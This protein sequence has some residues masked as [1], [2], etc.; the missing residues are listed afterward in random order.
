[1]QE[2]QPG[3][4]LRGKLEAAHSNGQ[5]QPGKGAGGGREAQAVN[6]VGLGLQ[7]A[8][9][10]RDGVKRVESIGRS[11]QGG[12]DRKESTGRSRRSLQ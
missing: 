9:V 5:Q 3:L 2:A 1:M 12:V 7:R 8:G 4:G 6:P 11:L 10:Q